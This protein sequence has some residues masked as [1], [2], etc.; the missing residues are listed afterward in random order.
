MIT[1]LAIR[2]LFRHRKRTLV[3][4]SAISFGVIALLIAGGF[5][6]WVFWGM[7]EGTIQSRFGHIQM[8]RPSYFEAGI[9][10][11][12]AYML[13]DGIGQQVK[14]ESLAH[15]DVI[16]KRLVLSGLVSHGDTSVGFIG[17]GMD[18]EKDS[19]VSKHLIIAE[20]DRLSADDPDGMLLGKGLAAS[21]GVGVGDSV[22]LLVTTATGGMNGVEGS[23]RGIFQ[24]MSSAYDAAALRLPIET[25][26]QL[27]RVQGEHS[28]VI[29]LDETKH[30]DTV[31]S[32]LQTDYP[33]EQFQVEFKPW[34][35]LA[36]FYNKT[37]KLY[38][39]QMDIIR[40]VIGLVIVLSISN[41]LAMSVHERTGE[42]GTLMAIGLKRRS[43]LQLFMTEGVLLGIVGG[44]LGVAVG[45][46]L[47]TT[48]SW[49]GIPMP[50]PPGMDVAVTGRIMISWSLVAGA[51]MLA[52]L[53]AFFGSIF[54]AMKAA[55]LEIV[56]ALR[57]SI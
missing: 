44:I 16:S 41:T 55:R 7:R 57:H 12:Y 40:L 51:L 17:E 23:V 37:V 39:R 24:S 14:P 38:S 4:L 18:P 32:Q 36:D 50:P 56:D 10:D 47:G 8:T 15:V 26:R 45:G 42:I 6:E 21:L 20:G 29:L 54:P 5:I 27:L 49:V 30:T 2:N 19:A 43:I 33:T 53:T 13:P 1:L 48:I 11:P 52:L 28:W 46:A 25:A 31:L 9:A 34:H 22:V 35:A 3:A